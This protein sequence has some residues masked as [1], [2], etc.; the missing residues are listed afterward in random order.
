MYRPM[1]LS[2]FLSIFQGTE[3]Q[4]AQSIVLRGANMFML[5]EMHRSVYDAL[6]AVRRTLESKRVVPGGGC[7][8]AAL[9]IHLENFARQMVCA[10]C[11]LI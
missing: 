3:S 10:C 2:S 1:E 11:V 9:S 4:R 6:C 8:E 7:V 5:D